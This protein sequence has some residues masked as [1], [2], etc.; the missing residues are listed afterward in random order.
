MEK[1]RLV[2]T[3]LTYQFLFCLGRAICQTILAKFAAWPGAV[4]LTDH[5]LRRT[6]FRRKQQMSF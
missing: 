4:P 2:L 3:R 6:R 5:I 1:K